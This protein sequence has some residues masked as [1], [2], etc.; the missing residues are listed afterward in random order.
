MRNLVLAIL[1][2]VPIFGKTI[3]QSEINIV[4]VYEKT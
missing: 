2:A 4:A 1:L 3:Y